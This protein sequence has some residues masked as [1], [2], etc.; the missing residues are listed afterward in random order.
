MRETYPTG[1]KLVGPEMPTPENIMEAANVA[2]AMW[3]K[4]QEA[5]G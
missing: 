5:S 2:V 1:I 3:G 4:R